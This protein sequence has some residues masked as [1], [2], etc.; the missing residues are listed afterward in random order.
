MA[1]WV[2]KKQALSSQLPQGSEDVAFKKTLGGPTIAKAHAA[3]LAN[4][5]RTLHDK[6]YPVSEGQS[7]PMV[8]DD[9]T[10]ATGCEVSLKA[11]VKIL[12]GSGPT[13]ASLDLKTLVGVYC[14]AAHYQIS[15]LKTA[16]VANVAVKTKIPLSEIASCITLARKCRH[17]FTRLSPL[18]LLLI[19]RTIKGI[20]G[21][22]RIMRTP[23]DL[24]PLKGHLG[25]ILPTGTD[26]DGLLDTYK[27]FLA[28]KVWV[29]FTVN[30][31]VPIAIINQR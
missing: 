20:P 6:F 3:V 9:W 30:L 2:P 24:D 29:F 22:V 13:F 15:E 25:K 8:L 18:L 11:F 28:L 10:H 23:L 4:Q 12:Y 7:F 31:Y 1:R 16:L 17:R 19:E 26:L 14:L 27:K 21:K 5:S